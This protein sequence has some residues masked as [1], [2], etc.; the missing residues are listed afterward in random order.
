MVIGFIPEF[1]LF[2]YPISWL[3]VFIS[4]Y[5][6]GFLWNTVPTTNLSGLGNMPLQKNETTNE[7]MK[8]DCIDKRM[9][10]RTREAKNVSDNHGKNNRIC[11]RKIKE[12]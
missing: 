11:E 3:D 1:D 8:K 6:T 12:E 2:F 7:R 10:D 4:E 9:K 5:N